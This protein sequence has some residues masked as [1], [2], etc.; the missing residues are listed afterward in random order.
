MDRTD[1]TRDPHL[2]R[3]VRDLD[4]ALG[5]RLLAVVLYG[6]AARGDYRQGTSDFNLIV[7]LQNLDPDG[8]EALSPALKW[9]ARQ[10]QPAPRL[11]SPAI[12]GE[13]ADVFPIEFLDIQRRRV[14]LHGQ[15]P[16]AT[17]AIGYD[18]LRLQCERELR[19][20]MMRLRE[21]YV[22]AHA[23][24]RAL[25]RLLT[26]SY[27]TF[28]AL[29]RGCLHLLGGESPLHNAEVVTAFCARADL[30][31]SPFLEVDRLKHGDGYAGDL[32]ALF[33]RYYEALT[34]AVH[35]IDRFEPRHGGQSS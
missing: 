16:F 30:D 26:D 2:Q 13:A 21:G 18:H 7:V 1:V 3:V 34:R 14:L 22:E 33:A 9:W 23:S 28:V 10:G 35:R 8:L 24:R 11:F 29:F 31:R 27:T 25:T 17:V 15:D 4:R 19:E 5:A 12:I 32:R 6:S 20:K